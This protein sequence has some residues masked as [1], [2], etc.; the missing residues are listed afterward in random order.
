M[1]C[2]KVFSWVIIQICTCSYNYKC[3][4]FYHRSCFS[5]KF[6]LFSTKWMQAQLPPLLV[7]TYTYLYSVR[8]SCKNNIHVEYC[9]IADIRYSRQQMLKTL[10]RSCAMPCIGLKFDNQS[11]RIISLTFTDKDWNIANNVTK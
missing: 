2:L 3:F 5:S 1:F 7:F 4:Y 8:L 10:K 11:A 9:I 6:V